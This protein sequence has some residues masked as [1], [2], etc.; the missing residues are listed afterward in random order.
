M[1]AR[2]QTLKDQLSR[3]R[4]IKISVTGRSSGRTITI[5]IWFVV[6]GDNIYL[7]P[8][9]G[10]DTQWYKNAVKS[11]S[12]RIQAGSAAADVTATALTKV[13]QVASVVEKFRAKYGA[14]DVKRYY[15]KLDVAMVAPMP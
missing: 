9:S 6:E 10:S 8:V 1:P 13:D 7:L 11:P 4:E 5:P 3:R 2:S 12:L 14:A 15:S